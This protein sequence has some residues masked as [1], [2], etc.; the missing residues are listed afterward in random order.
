[1]SMNRKLV[2]SRLI[3]YWQWSL[4]NHILEPQIIWDIPS[5]LL[6]PT[7][8]PIWSVL[9]KGAQLDH[10]TILCI[11]H[12][13]QTQ[14]LCNPNSQVSLCV[15]IYAC[16][17]MDVAKGNEN[18][19]AEPSWM[20]SYTSNDQIGSS[21]FPFRCLHFIKTRTYLIKRDPLTLGYA[22]RF[23]GAVPQF[24]AWCVLPDEHLA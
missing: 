1:M 13:Y 24:T 2:V 8:N 10:T 20:L 12:Y 15:H 23:D 21:V 16:P 11:I 5:T 19:M 4:V 7:D 3:L 9:P 14:I 6:G 22:G 17:I 18:Q